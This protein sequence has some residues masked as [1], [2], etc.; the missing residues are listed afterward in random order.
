MF[1]IATEVLP[2]PVLLQVL[3]V[4]AVDQVLDLCQRQ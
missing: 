2:I 4:E 3:F 1:T